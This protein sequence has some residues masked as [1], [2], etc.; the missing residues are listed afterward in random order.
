V[1]DAAHALYIQHSLARNAVLI[2]LESLDPDSKQAS[3]SSTTELK[4]PGENT[5]V[6][7][8]VDA[9]RADL[10]LYR[11]ALRHRLRRAVARSP[12]VGEA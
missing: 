5:S 3:Q 12:F 7:R 10:G 1:R 11:P 4:A 9:A 8:L 2:A 6:A